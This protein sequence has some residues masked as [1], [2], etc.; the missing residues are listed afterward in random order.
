MS[1]HNGN[2]WKGLLPDYM[3]QGQMDRMSQLLGNAMSLRLGSMSGLVDERRSINDEC[4]YKETKDITPQLFRE[5]YDREPIASR[6]VEVMPD[7][8]W[9]QVPEVIEVEDSGTVTEFE[10]AW[11]TLP[12]SLTGESLYRGDGGNPIWEFL[13]R[14]DVM[15]G[16]GSYGVMLL[17]LD[18][19]KELSDPVDGI[20]ETGKSSIKVADR[21]LLYLRVFDQSIARIS[22]YENGKGNPRRGQPLTYSLTLSDPSLQAQTGIGVEITEA[23]VHWTRVIHYAKN[24]LSSEVWGRSEMLSVWNPLVDIQKIRGGDAE[25]FWKASNPILNLGTHPQLGG[26]VEVDLD[27][28]KDQ[29]EQIRN[30]LQRELITQGMA[31]Q[32]L[33]PSVADPTSHLDAQ[34][35]HICIKKGIPRRVFEGSERG[36]L[37]SSQDA[38]AWNRRVTRTRNRQVTPKILV[39]FVDRL[40]AVGVLPSPEEYMARWPDAESETKLERAQIADARVGVMTKYLQ[41]GVESLMAPHDLMTRE[42]DYDDEEAESVLE[43]AAD[44]KEE[45]DEEQAALQEEQAQVQADAMKQAGINP[46]QVPPNVP[47]QPPKIPGQVAKPSPFQKK[48]PQFQ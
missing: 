32:Q 14:L 42:L 41:G 38:I 34:I 13:Y 30:S 10:E 15:A 44:L 37:A 26:D 46:Q 5:M 17:G 16:I 29:L 40:I 48:P 18:D 21:K 19:G 45:K 11:D 4:G 12:R 22:A 9:Q 23:Q 20:D 8:C 31:V 39:P 6:V 24:L 2:G 47:G 1:S 43:E 35:G 25:G 36:E 28:L 7:E 27:E 3:G 33:A